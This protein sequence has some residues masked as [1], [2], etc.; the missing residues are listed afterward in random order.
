MQLD[1]TTKHPQLLHTVYYAHQFTKIYFV[2][3]RQ[4]YTGNEGNAA[5]QEAKLNVRCL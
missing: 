3:I 1:L 4:M 2:R 5:L